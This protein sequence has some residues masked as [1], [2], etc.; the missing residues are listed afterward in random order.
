M[1]STFSFVLSGIL[2]S[3]APNV[4]AETSSGPGATVIDLSMYSVPAT[5]VLATMH[6]VSLDP[7]SVAAAGVS[8]NESVAM[9]TAAAAALESSAQQLAAA[10][11]ALGAARTNV[12]SLERLIRAGQAQDTQAA[13][14]ALNA[15]RATLTSATTVRDAVLVTLIEA[16]TANLSN[17]QKASLA[18]IRTS[19]P[20]WGELPAAYRVIASEDTAL[21]DLRGALAA[22]RIALRANE[23]V[24]DDAAA[25]LT[26]WSQSPAV[27]TALAAQDANA[28]MIAASWATSVQPGVP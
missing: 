8:L 13:V 11:D 14:A 3:A 23:P 20:T 19:S 4:G 22:K 9:L 24:P 26:Q 15:A 25:I 5:T 28:A 7:G 6:R 27:S 2:A 18:T 16:A 12:D 17:A 1:I 21:L 10:D